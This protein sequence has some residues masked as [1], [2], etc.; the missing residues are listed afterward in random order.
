[1]SFVI[2]SLQTILDKRKIAV[3]YLKNM[4]FVDFFSTIPF[5]IGAFLDEITVYNMEFHF[6]KTISMVKIFRL[7]TFLSYF[8][9]TL[10]LTK[11]LKN[12]YISILSFMLGYLIII[13]WA[14]SLEIL[15]GLI[16]AKF[17][18]KANVSAW[19]EQDD[20]QQK[21]VVYK[22]MT[23][24]FKSITTIC[25]TGASNYEPTEVFDKI[26]TGFLLV[27]G[28]V[29][30]C[31][32]FA[33]IYQIIQGMN[34][35]ELRFGEVVEQLDRY[36]DEMGLPEQTK[37]TFQNNFLFINKKIFLFQN[38]IKNYY[39]YAYDRKFFKDDETLKSLPNNLKQE[40]IMHNTA[41]LVENCSFFQNLPS[42][43][44]MKIVSALSVEIFLE[45]V[46]IYEVGQLC[47]SMYFIASGSTAFYSPTGKEL[48]HHEDFDYFGEIE[49]LC[50]RERRYSTCVALE[51][52]VC[53]K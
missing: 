38:K 29:G 8:R 22:Y 33:K 14:S 25:G 28:R 19:Y 51:T 45:N 30:L 46:E 20:F 26:Y 5:V 13:Y 39:E 9:R 12:D 3:N 52:T 16:A 21:T 37:V 50:E 27:T 6:F 10:R 47:D 48:W 43:L 7:F 11:L 36:G 53:F 32:L 17:N 40:I 15:P 1:M 31:V 2:P 23:C 35:A 44:Q 24:I 42:S 41:E 18:V 4:F 34:S 49:L